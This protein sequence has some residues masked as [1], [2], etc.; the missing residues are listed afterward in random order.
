MKQQCLILFSSWVESPI[1]EGELKCFRNQGVLNCDHGI[2]CDKDLGSRRVLGQ[3]ALSV[4][5]DG[6]GDLTRLQSVRGKAAASILLCC[7]YHVASSASLLFVCCLFDQSCLI[8]CDSMDVAHQVP[9]SVG[10]PRQEY[11]SRL[12]FP[13]PGDLPDPGIKAASPA[14]QV[15]SLQLSH[16]GP[17]EKMGA[18]SRL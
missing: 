14:L 7:L 10:F 3:V 12:L 17:Q 4:S 5:T 2:F 6:P 18:D 9:L 11:W 16:Q 1:R 15:V 13:S 8:L